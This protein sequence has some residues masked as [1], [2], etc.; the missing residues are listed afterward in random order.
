VGGA[1]AAASGA[2]I[3][4][5][6][7]QSASS[8][9]NTLDDYEEGT[10]TPTAIG[11]S[12][13]GTTTYTAQVGSYIKIGN[14]VTAQFGIGYSALTGTGELVISLPFTCNAEYI[15]SVMTNNLNWPGGTSMVIYTVTSTA[16]CR[17][18]FSTDD[19]GWQV[20]QCVNESVNIIGTVTYFVS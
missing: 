3:T 16:G 19:A 17:L 7:T 5:P 6:A 2:G 18:F 20:Q 4:F 14:Q 11:G 1:T 10:W 15:G 13:A 12:T 8:N 9:A